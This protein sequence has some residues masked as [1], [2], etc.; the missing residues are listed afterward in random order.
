MKILFMNIDLYWDF[1]Y[2]IE[3]DYIEISEKFKLKKNRSEST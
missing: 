2:E 1:F 3:V